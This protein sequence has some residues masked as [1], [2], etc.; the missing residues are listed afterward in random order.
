S[1]IGLGVSDFAKQNKIPFLA[2]E[3]LADALIWER[4][5]RYTFRV[6]SGTYM[7]SAM[8]VE[9]VAKLPAKRWAILAPNFEFGHSAAT[10]FKTLLSQ[11]RP[12]IEWVGEQFPALGNLDAGSTVQALAAAKPEALFNATFGSDLVR[13]V[14][15][16]NDRDFLKDLTVASVLTGQ[17]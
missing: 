2:A 8:L 13:F 10:A 1:N 4:G 3:A 14:R 7:Q 15:A 5:N 12:D 9:Q 6:R 11:R 16:A 17:P